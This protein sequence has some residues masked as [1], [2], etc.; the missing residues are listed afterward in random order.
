M[1]AIMAR[2][3]I[4]VA[5]DGRLQ[6]QDFGNISEM[7]VN[8][9][10]NKRYKIDDLL[11]LIDEERERQFLIPIRQK[12]TYIRLSNGTIDYDSDIEDF[13]I[14]NFEVDGDVIEYED[15]QKV[16]LPIKRD[17]DDYASARRRD[18]RN[19]DNGDYIFP[20][21]NTA[22]LELLESY[23]DLYMAKD[24]ATRRQFQTYLSQ[25]KDGKLTEKSM[26]AML[27]IIGVEKFTGFYIKQTGH[28]F[29]PNM[30]NKILSR[31]EKRERERSRERDGR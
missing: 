7:V 3:N 1:K 17:E 2:Q 20:E 15:S 31:R 19:T 13:Y 4:G 12:A 5:D 6:L 9:K 16:R 28:T 29:L 23:N 26:T 27:G 10:N 21:S 30:A 24:S 18:S 14:G 22:L 8:V 25:L 11:V